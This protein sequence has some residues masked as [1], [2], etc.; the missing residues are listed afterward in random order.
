MKEMVSESKP[1]FKS[2]T[3]CLVVVV[4][5]VVARWDDTP[6]FHSSDAHAGKKNTNLLSPA[7]SVSRISPQLSTENSESCIPLPQGW[8]KRTRKS[9]HYHYQK[10]DKKR[11]KSFKE[12]L[13]LRVKKLLIRENHKFSCNIT[14]IILLQATFRNR[15]DIFI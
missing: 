8:K 14:T 5:V 12:G 13:K 1:V 4:V 2:S 15:G 3:E 10:V 9:Q 11:K 7:P 6:C